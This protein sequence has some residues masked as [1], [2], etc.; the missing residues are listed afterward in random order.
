[1]EQVIPTVSVCTWISPYFIY[2]SN[3]CIQ[4]CSI[5]FS[6]DDISKYM[7]LMVREIDISNVDPPLIRRNTE[8]VFLLQP[9]EWWSIYNCHA[10]SFDRHYLQIFLKA[11]EFF[12]SNFWC[13]LQNRMNYRVFKPLYRWKICLFG[14]YIML[15]SFIFLRDFT[16]VMG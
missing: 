6:E 16:L 3:I 10:P 2:P 8:F 12:E 11:I 4:Y 13:E 7:T 15:I 5:P 14:G 9:S 1:M